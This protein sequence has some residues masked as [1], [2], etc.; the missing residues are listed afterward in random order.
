MIAE[1]TDEE[2]EAEIEE[3]ELAN[4]ARKRAIEETEKDKALP[5]LVYPP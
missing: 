1:P 3:L 5:G 4:E 2:I